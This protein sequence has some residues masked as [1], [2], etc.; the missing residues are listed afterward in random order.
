M[1]IF[2]NVSNI[3]FVI[4]VLSLNSCETATKSIDSTGEYYFYSPKKSGTV[5]IWD[6]EQIVMENGNYLNLELV[7]NEPLTNNNI[8]TL[9]LRLPAHLDEA[10]LIN[11]EDEIKEKYQTYCKVNNVN[12][13]IRFFIKNN[14]SIHDEESIIVYG[15]GIGLL[16]LDNIHF[17]TSLKLN[18]S[19]K[20]QYES[21]LYLHEKIE[22]IVRLQ[23]LDN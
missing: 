14:N 5:Q 20:L 23:V 11:K 10:S 1:Q 19:S 16:R 6:F 13:K 7:L 22:E 12:Y 15:E 8:D 4:I 17:R 9:L 2:Q 18:R 21:I 3:I